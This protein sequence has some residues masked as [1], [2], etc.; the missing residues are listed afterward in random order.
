MSYF[1]NQPNLQFFFFENIN[2]TAQD[3]ENDIQTSHSPQKYAQN[4]PIF[5]D[6]YADCDKV[7]QCVKFIPILDKYM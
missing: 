7:T 3:K 6:F 4:W 5:A 2:I 1:K